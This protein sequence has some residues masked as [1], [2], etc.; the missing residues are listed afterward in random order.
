MRTF[1][2]VW[3]GQVISLFGSAMTGFALTT[4]AWQLT[5]SATAL[6]LVGFFHFAPTVLFS[7]IAGALV[8][9]WNRKLVMMFSDLGTGLATIAILGLYSAGRLEIWHLYVAGVFAGTFQAFQWPAYGAATT[10][11]LPKAQYGRASGMISLAESAANTLAPLLAGVLIVTIG[12]TGIL[13]IDI[14]TFLFAIGALLIVRLPQPKTTAEGR[15]GQGSLLQE[16]AYG[17]RYIVARPSLLGLQLVFFVGNLMASLGMTVMAPMIL[18]Q[19]RNS[20]TILGS[21]QSAGA[22]GGVVGGVLIAAWGGPKRRVHG[23]L[24]GHVVTGLTEATRAFGL[25]F[26]YVG[27]FAGSGTVPILNGSNQALWQAKVA[28]DVQGRVFSVRRLIAQVSAPLAILAAGPLADRVFEPGM[29]PGGALAGAFGALVGTGPGHGM[30][31]MTLLAGLAMA[32]AGAVSYAIPAVRNAEELL[33]DYQAL[34]ME[35]A[36]AGIGAL[37]APETV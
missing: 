34:T 4:W 14:A 3:L 27:N 22:L 26:W 19:T 7:P 5:N 25:S 10:L 21:V 8:D 12:L 1:L 31:L 29:Q 15:A 18:A 6:A 24:L 37:A 20:A 11:L 33:P 23:V 13:L 35:Q 9:R 28:P 17:F 2:T 16:A 30:A 36:D 32:L